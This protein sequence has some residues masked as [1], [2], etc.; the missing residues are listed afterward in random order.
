M[1][2][3]QVNGDYLP[4]APQLIS[5]KVPANKARCARDHHSPEISICNLACGIPPSSR[6]RWYFLQ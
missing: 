6:I 3:I 2:G 4:P 5:N 1:P